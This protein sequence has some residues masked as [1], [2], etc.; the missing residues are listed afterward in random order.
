MASLGIIFSSTIIPNSYA[1]TVI[2]THGIVA[3]D[4]DVLDTLP[5]ELHGRGNLQGD[6]EPVN[7]GTLLTCKEWVRVS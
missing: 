6:E 2:R 5:T 7:R 3:P 1:A 4:W